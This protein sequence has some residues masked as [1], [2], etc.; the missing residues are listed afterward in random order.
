MLVQHIKVWN[1]LWSS[2]YWAVIHPTAGQQHTA[3]TIILLFCFYIVSFSCENYDR[4]TPHKSYMSYVWQQKHSKREK[5]LIVGDFNHCILKGSEWHLCGMLEYAL[6]YELKLQTLPGSMQ[7]GKRQDKQKK[8]VTTFL[9]GRACLRGW[10]SCRANSLNYSVQ[11][12]SPS[13]HCH[14]YS[15]GQFLL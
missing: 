3:T 15:G 9:G 5:N 6:A 8:S 2:N 7:E 13:Y 14:P 12:L 1:G 4:K 10:N 11:L